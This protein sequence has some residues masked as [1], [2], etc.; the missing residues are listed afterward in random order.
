[1]GLF[2]VQDGGA[3]LPG[4]IAS[5]HDGHVH[6]GEISGLIEFMYG[7]GESAGRTLYP[8]TVAELSHSLSS[9]MRTAASPTERTPGRA[10]RSSV[11]R[12]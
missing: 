3:V 2:A 11:K 7:S 10:L 4:E 9:K 12:W 5:F 1:M 6:G 8:S